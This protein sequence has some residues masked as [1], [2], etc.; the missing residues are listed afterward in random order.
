M[1]EYLVEW[2]VELDAVGPRK[3]AREALEMHRDKGSTSTV[4]E[5]TNKKSGTKFLVDLSENT[6][7][8]VV[9]NQRA[10]EASEKVT[11]RVGLDDENP[12]IRRD[13]VVARVW[14]DD[15]V[16]NIK[17]D[18][19]P[20]L[21][22]ASDSD[23]SDLYQVGFSRDYPA[24]KVARFMEERSTEIAGMFQYIEVLRGKKDIGFDVEVNAEQMLLWL[25]L[26]KPQLWERY[27]EFKLREG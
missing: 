12:E 18:A 2:K 23:I 17:F 10:D 20:W 3:A 22:E 24:D 1:A 6:C 25:K 9:P 4:F 21:K 27:N 5:V 26:N 14:S 7:V 19:V 13:A 11:A 8:I 16:F 15:K